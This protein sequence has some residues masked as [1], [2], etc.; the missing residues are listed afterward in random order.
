MLHATPAAPAC[1][2]VPLS[3]YQVPILAQ[4]G[5]GV[6]LGEQGRDRRRLALHVTGGVTLPSRNG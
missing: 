1:T 5:P 3:G 6:G 4:E 2:G